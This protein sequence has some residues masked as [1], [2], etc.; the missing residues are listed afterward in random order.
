LKKALEGKDIED[1][2]TKTDDLTKAIYDVTSK[3]Y[4]QTGAQ[5]A[6]GGAGGAGPFGTGESDAGAD[7]TVD[8][9]FKVM[10]DDDKNDK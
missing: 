6:A 9:D 10:D 4:Q 1:I 8:A 2:K 3:V 5:D 7:E